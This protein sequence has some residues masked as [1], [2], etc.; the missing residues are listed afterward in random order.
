MLLYFGL[1][2][3]T[4]EYA[5]T[6]W[7]NITV[8]DANK[9]ESVQWKFTVLCFTR[10]LPHIPSNY[11]CTLELPQLHALQ[12]RMLHFDAVFFRHV[13]SGS[14]FCPSLIDCVSVPSCNIRTFT[15]FYI[16]RRSFSSA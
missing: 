6:V 16:A 1:V 4:L 10:F 13:F 8:T 12:V 11:A 15:Q 2:K 7:N 5:S 9:L 14:K 3:C